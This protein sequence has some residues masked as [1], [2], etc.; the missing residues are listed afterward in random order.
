VGLHA[1]RMA[2]RDELWKV[3]LAFAPEREAALAADSR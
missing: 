1:E 3:I 2:V